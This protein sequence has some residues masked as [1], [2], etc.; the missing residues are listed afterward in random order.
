MAIIQRFWTYARERPPVK[1]AVFFGALHGSA[2]FCLFALLSGDPRFPSLNLWYALATASLFNACFWINDDIKDEAFDRLH[3]PT[4]AAVRGAVKY[5]DLKIVALSMFILMAAINVGRGFP[6][7]VAL[8]WLLM[9]AL[10]TKAYYFPEAMEQSFAL[11]ISTGGHPMLI[12]GNLYFYAAFTTSGQ[13]SSLPIVPVIAVCVSLS[14][15]IMA[16]EIARKTR[17]AEQETSFPS[18]SKR[19][20]VRNAALIPPVYY[21]I[22]TTTFALV[23]SSFGLSNRFIIAQIIVGAT[24]TAVFVQFAVRPTASRNHLRRTAE[25]YDVFSKLAIIAEVAI[26][27]KGL[28]NP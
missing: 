18:Y 27:L 20:G 24:A 11:T 15:P 1:T 3:N 22:I 12:L 6:T 9:L 23:G 14:A 13:I 19:W 26:Q 5:A 4:R 21:L 2:A 28:A 17:A 7:D 25:L 16:W 10:W 8:I